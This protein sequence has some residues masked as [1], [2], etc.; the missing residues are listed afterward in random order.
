MKTYDVIVIGAGSGLLISSQ[1]ANAGLNVAVI[2][3]DKFGGTC[4]LRG[5]IPSKILIHHADIARTIKNSAEFGIKSKLLSVDFKKIVKEVSD[6]VD[7]E[8][9]QIEQGNKNDKNITV[10]K[11]RAEFTG[12]NTVKVVFENKNAAKKDKEKSE[13]IYGKKIFICAGTRASVPP[14]PGLN[15]ARYLTSTEALRLQKQPKVL[16]IIGGG[17]IAAELAYF[18]GE[19]GTK[20]NIVERENIMLKNEDKEISEVFTKIAG[21]KYNLNLGAQI[22]NVSQKGN[23]NT[24]KFIVEIKNA[25]G[26]NRKIVSDQ[27]LVA[28]GRVPNTDV[29]KVQNAGVK[30]NKYGYIEVNQYLETSQKNIWAIGDIAGIYLFK[31]SANLEAEYAYHNAFSSD[32]NKTKDNKQI[33]KPVNYY[34]MPHAVFTNPQIAGV[35]LREQDLTKE[36]V[37]TNKNNNEIE[38]V[39]AKHYF[40]NTGMGRALHDDDGFVKFIVEKKTGKILGCH[41]I[42]AEASTLIHEVLVVMKA[43]GNVDTIVNT[44][45]IHPALSEVVQRAAR[46][47]KY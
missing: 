26:K 17:Y 42:G 6:F 20:I 1:A 24:D 3:E 23:K 5:C 39:I 18:F 10:Y 33:K 8:A 36:N 21:K 40:K 11:G 34:P 43:G 2:E 38:Y 41:I 4:L 47:A 37:G 30:A 29:L 28:T 7:N 19:L 32:K 14:I 12:K 27:L 16:T 25:H 35:G 46:K 31:H 9:K 22:L 45:H 44:V 15:N 13:E